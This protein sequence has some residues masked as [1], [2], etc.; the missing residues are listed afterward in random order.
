MAPSSGQRLAI[1]D[2][3]MRIVSV[4]A[5]IRQQV[6]QA[7][8]TA[9]LDGRFEPGHRLVE[10]Q[11]CALTGASRTS[12]R[13]SLRQLET[14]GLVH[15][16]PNRGPIVASIDIEEAKGIFEVR[17]VLE[18]L[19]GRSFTFNAT[20]AQMNAFEDATR[21]VIK[22][23]RTNDVAM[24][25]DR[26]NKFYECLLAGSGNE[27][28]NSIARTLQARSNLLRQL[29]FS[30]KGRLQA[31]VK[32]VKA[33][34]MAIKARDAAAAAAACGAHVTNAAEE[35]ERRHPAP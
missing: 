19:I 16:V 7:L 17:A 27:V 2:S 24:I 25:I 14:E 33:I 4:A 15:I 3:E 31:S 22:A 26:K 1:A 9:I 11:L 29:S 10:K 23:Y 21:E 18:A 28:A 30:H 13:E 6:T 8:R 5:P 20:K 12:V 32:E 35:L 34:L